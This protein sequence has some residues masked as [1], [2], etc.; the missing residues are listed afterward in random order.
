LCGFSQALYAGEEEKRMKRR[1]FINT[2]TIS[3]L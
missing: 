2:L 3:S 1:C